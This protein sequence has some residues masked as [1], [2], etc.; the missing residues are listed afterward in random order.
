VLIKDDL[1]TSGAGLVALLFKTPFILLRPLG[2]GDYA[3][4][5][6]PTLIVTF[7]ALAALAF[8]LR[9]GYGLAGLLWVL[10]CCAP[11]VPLDKL[12]SRYLYLPAIGYSLVFCA[13]CS[14]LAPHLR[15]LP[16]RRLAGVALALAVLSIVVGNALLVQR[17][18]ADYRQLA[19]PYSALVDQVA[20]GLAGIAEGE[21]FLVVD[22]ARQT[23]IAELTR[24]I[25]ERGNMTKLIPYRRHAIDG[26]IE[27]PDLLNVARP[28]EAGRLGRAESVADDASI[29]WFV[30]DG[31]RLVETAPRDGVPPERV[32]RA[33]WGAAAEFFAR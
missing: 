1:H 9:R 16:L 7:A 32:H 3:R 2:L 22:G 24:R 18:I 29:R 10:A 13:V 23:T 6:A 5:D 11:I 25:E 20:P 21:T 33:T 31:T 28:R 17:E 27:L 4:F 15:S 19:A 14:A 26:L 30:Y 12:S 8:W